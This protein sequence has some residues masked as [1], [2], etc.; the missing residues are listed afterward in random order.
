MG[1]A[2]SHSSESTLTEPEP[3]SRLR[4]VKS[5]VQTRIPFWGKKEPEKSVETNGTSAHPDNVS[6]DYTSDMVDVLDTIGMWSP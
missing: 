2:P 6:M 3:Q 1:Q 5:A 4:K